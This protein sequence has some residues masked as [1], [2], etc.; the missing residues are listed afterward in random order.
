MRISKF[1][2]QR[3]QRL[4]AALVIR[5]IAD[6]AKQDVAFKPRRRSDTSRGNV[7]VHETEFELLV[8]GPQFFD[9]RVSKGGGGAVDLV[10]HV[11]GID[12]KT[13]VRLLEKLIL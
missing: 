8:T 13:A 2:L 10:M 5:G 12:F 11:Y 4:D 1:T 6:Y 7:R 3:W 9:P